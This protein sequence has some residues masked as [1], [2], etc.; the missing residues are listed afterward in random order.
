MDAKP[1]FSAYD[2]DRPYLFVSYSH[3]DGATVYADI[4]RLHDQGYRVWY[5]EGIEPG[6]EWPEDVAKALDGCSLFLLFVS[7]NAVASHNVRNEIHFAISRKKPILAVHLDE[8]EMPKGLELQLGSI[9]AVMRYRESDEEYWRRMDRAFGSHQYLRGEAPPRPVGAPPPRT[10]KR[11]LAASAVAAGLAVLSVAGWWLFGRRTATFS[12]PA[13]VVANAA[14]SDTAVQPAQAVPPQKKAEPQSG[15]AQPRADVPPAAVPARRSPAGVVICA[16]GPGARALQG[17]LSRALTE[18]RVKIVPAERSVC[19]EL[20]ESI[21]SLG[22][23]P[24]AVANA[25]EAKAYVAI[26]TSV[27]IEDPTYFMASANAQAT[28]ALFDGRSMRTQDFAFAPGRVGVQP[29]EASATRMSVTDLVEQ[30]AA[31]IEQIADAVR[32]AQ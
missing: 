12:E 7:P 30:N 20:V 29:D 31:T 18:R 15:Q 23:V 28:V 25:P 13:A 11:W 24:Q 10:T 2:G 16:T 17:A 5:D 1:P 21:V 8:T 22:T 9:Q 19:D 14:P 6:S 32:A 4:A 3:R 27:T 26:Q